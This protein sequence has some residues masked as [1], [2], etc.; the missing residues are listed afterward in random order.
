MFDWI[1]DPAAWAAL[2]TLTALEIVL[3]IDN[4][5][6][7][8]ILTGRLP[9]EQQGK[10]RTIGLALAMGM[11][12]LLLL[13]I[14]WVMGL[15]TVLFDV[16]DWLPFLAD[17]QPVGEATGEAVVG[18]GGGD[19]AETS[20]TA[21]T[22]RDLILLLGGIFLVGKATHEIHNKLEGDGE[23]AAAKPKA[24]TMGSV[25][26][27]I[28]LLDLVFS[29]DSVITAVGMADDIA[30]MIIAV[31]IAVGVMMLGAGP[32]SNFVHRHPTVKMLAL[33]F[34]ILIG[35]TL[36]A[37]GMGQHISKGYIYSAMAFSLI[38]E[39]LN[40]RSKRGKDTP[41]VELQEPYAQ[42]GTSGVPTADD[43]ARPLPIAPP[44]VVHPVV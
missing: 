21:I 13:S 43:V 27:Q 22:G 15:T 35:V 40:I 25:L 33:A 39:F 26:I 31:V 3:G 41:S 32:I 36:V 8:S 4:I 44:R 7:I 9:E 28:A 23:H 10:G 16:A 20:A 19:V 38:V 37:E 1:S 30:V 24:A 11:R 14:S 42:A 5:I 29:L 6:F 34:L 18:H 17:L 12:I 2:G